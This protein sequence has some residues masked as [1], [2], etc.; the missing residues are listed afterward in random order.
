MYYS[1]IAEVSNSHNAN[2]STIPATP[3]M[4]PNTK[5]VPYTVTS[6]YVEIEK[7]VKVLVIRRTYTWNI[8]REREQEQHT[9][10]D[11]LTG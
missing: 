4:L 2:S 7:I 6:L 9:W 11:W 8:E 1:E 5:Y 3:L 10:L